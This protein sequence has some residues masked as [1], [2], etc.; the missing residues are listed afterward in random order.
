MAQVYR[1]HLAYYYMDHSG[2]NS[3]FLGTANPRPI[4]P[5]QVLARDL[6]SRP[7][8]PTPNPTQ[9]PRVA[10]WYMHRPQSYDMETPLRPMRVCTDIYIYTY[11]YRATLLGSMIPYRTVL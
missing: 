1:I 6:N 5:G 2:L 11:I 8:H 9:R 10:P 3:L 7:S 4:P